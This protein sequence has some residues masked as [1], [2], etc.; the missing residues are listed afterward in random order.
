MPFSQNTLREA[1][2]LAKGRCE[3]Q[4][5]GHG[6]AERC[7]EEIVW[8]RYGLIGVGGWQARPWTPLEEGGGDDVENCEIVCWKCAAANMTAN[9]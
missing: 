5:E 6:H 1:Y 7:G 4:R 2:Y 9:P 3:C 8:Q